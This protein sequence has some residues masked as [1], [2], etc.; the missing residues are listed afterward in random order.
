[1]TRHRCVLA[2]AAVTLFAAAACGSDNDDAPEEPAGSSAS[3]KAD[4]VTTAL[5]ERVRAY[6]DAYFAPDADTAYEMLSQRCQDQINADAYATQL[7]QA[8]ADYGQLAVETLTVDEVAGDMA[9]V[10][11]TVG[12]PKFDK[13]LVEQPWVRDG[14][15]WQYDAC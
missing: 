13:Q 2:L 3:G 9:R 4:E 6:T 15:Q 8:A 12:L 14:G 7:D 1:M 10:T 11:Y 5:E